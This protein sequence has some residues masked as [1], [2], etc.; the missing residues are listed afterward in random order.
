MHPAFTDLNAGMVFTDIN[1][2]EF[3]ETS[4]ALIFKGMGMTIAN[5]LINP[6]LRQEKYQGIPSH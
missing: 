2:N 3:N 6:E 1:S 4:F 5:C